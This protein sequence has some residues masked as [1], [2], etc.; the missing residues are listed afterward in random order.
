M[1]RL[2]VCIFLSLSCALIG[3]GSGLS[4]QE[5]EQVK[6]AVKQGLE[7]WQ[8]KKT[9]ASAKTIP[10]GWQFLD[11]DWK[12]GSTLTEF[13]ITNVTVDKDKL[14]RCWVTLK[15]NK[16]GKPISREVCYIVDLSRKMI[17]RDPYL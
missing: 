15:L 16:Q 3:C 5:I 6:S 8:N 4:S 10:D 17:N 1:T 11:E 14:P 2:S 7:I 9:P 13:T 12:A